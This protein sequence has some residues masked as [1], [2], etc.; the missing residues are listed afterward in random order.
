MRVHGSVHVSCYKTIS[1]RIYGCDK[2]PGKQLFIF[3][4]ENLPHLDECIA[5]AAAAAAIA[6]DF[7]W[8]T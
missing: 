8:L 1:K 2:K 6:L 7:S 3:V 4:H 5:A